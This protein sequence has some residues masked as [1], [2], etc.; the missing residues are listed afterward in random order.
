MTPEWELKLK[1]HMFNDQWAA[2]KEQ[3]IKDEIPMEEEDEPLEFGSVFITIKYW[4]EMGWEAREV[5]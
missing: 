5:R 4:F 3:C 1:G 2:F